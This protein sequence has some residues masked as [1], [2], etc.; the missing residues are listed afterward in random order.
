MEL[1]TDKN[2]PANACQHPEVNEFGL[3][4]EGLLTW[5]RTSQAWRSL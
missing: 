5:Q 4:R 2:K 3:K 1:A